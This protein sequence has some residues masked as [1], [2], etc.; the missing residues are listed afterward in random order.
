M[1]KLRISLH[2]VSVEA[3][4]EFLSCSISVSAAAGSAK[5]RCVCATWKAALWLPL[6]DG[7]SSNPVSI[8]TS[9]LLTPPSTPQQHHPISI[10][11]W[12]RHSRPSFLSVSASPLGRLSHSLVSHAGIT[13]HPLQPSLLVY[14]FVFK[15]G[16][17][18][19]RLELEVICW[20]ICSHPEG[21][22]SKFLCCYVV[23]MKSLEMNWE[24]IKS[25]SLKFQDAFVFFSLMRVRTCYPFH[26]VLSRIQQ[27]T[28]IIYKYTASPV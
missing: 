26:L 15:T 23:W 4:V 20:G 24:E 12:V 2:Y 1:C 28:L 9:P 6:I 7:D 19:L 13:L 27:L 14:M 25:V 16:R 10:L 8:P 22:R 5:Q 17:K 18:C 11:L 21:C 3:V